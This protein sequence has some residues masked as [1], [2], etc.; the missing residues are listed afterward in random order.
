MALEGTGKPQ[1]N[2]VSKNFAYEQGTG[3]SLAGKPE[4]NWPMLFKNKNKKGCSCCLWQQGEAQWVYLA[5]LKG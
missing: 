3:D 2:E 5:I 1:R 4:E